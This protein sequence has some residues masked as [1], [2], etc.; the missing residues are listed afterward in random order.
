[1]QKDIIIR[2]WGIVSYSS[3]NH[4][5][6]RK[7]EKGR[8]H[9]YF[10]VISY[11][12][13]ENNTYRW[14]HTPVY[15][16]F[17]SPRVG[18]GNKNMECDSLLRPSFLYPKLPCSE[19]YEMLMRVGEMSRCSV[20]MVPKYVQV[21]VNQPARQSPQAGQANGCPPLREPW[22]GMFNSQKKQQLFERSHHL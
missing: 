2:V 14:H 1:M 18:A 9:T 3:G 21:I 19:N 17:E 6:R 4:V 13:Y 22:K 8:F 7:Y 11:I 15:I 16:P 12:E 10:F 20:E 5:F